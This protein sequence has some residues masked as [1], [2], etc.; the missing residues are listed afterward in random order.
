MPR[1]KLFLVGGPSGA[2]KDALLTGARE[3][4]VD[5]AF[6]VR[7]VTR[8]ADQCSDLER[9]VSSALRWRLRAALRW[10]CNPRTT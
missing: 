6:V 2:G 9:S 4:A 5:V 7:D 3:K 1:P 10:S 8:G